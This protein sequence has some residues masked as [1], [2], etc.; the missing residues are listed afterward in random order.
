MLKKIHD[1]IKVQ[2]K[3]ICTDVDIANQEKMVQTF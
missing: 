2:I 3:E 1:F